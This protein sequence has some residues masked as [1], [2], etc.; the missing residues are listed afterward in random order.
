MDLAE[1]LDLI[2]QA[3]GKQDGFCFFPWID[4]TATDREQRIKSYHEGPA[5]HWPADRAQVLLHMHEH[6]ND[7]LYWC[8]S[9]FETDRRQLEVAMDEHALWADLDDVD[10]REIDEEYKPT[11]A[12]ETS[13]GRYQGLWLIQRGFDIQGASWPGGENQKLTYY[14]GADVG[15]WDITQL[16]RIPGW[17]NHKPEHRGGTR[18][19]PN[20]KLTKPPTGKLLWYDKSRRYLPDHFEDLPEVANAL[21]AIKDVLD[22][23]IDRV[24][25][26]A[27]WGRVRLKVSRRVRE[28]VG[29]KEVT[30]DRS[31]V[32]WEIERELADAGCSVVEIVAIVRET[33]WNKYEG[34]AD[35]LRR[36]TNE[37]A[38]AVAARPDK[39]AV[40]ADELEPSDDEER[41]N[42]QRLGSLL[43]TV[44][45]PA[46]LVEGIWTK[47]SCGFIAGQPKTFKS[48]CALDIALSVATG[49]P[50]LGHFPVRV[51]GPVLY[52]QEED[53]LPLL[54]QRADKVWPGKMADRM[55][56]MGDG[57]IQWVPG[58]ELGDLEDAP[59]DAYIG[60]GFTLSD[61]GW[62]SWLDE[63]L[64]A[65]EYVMLVMD[66][67]MMLAGDVEENRAQ[68]MTTKIFRPLKQLAQK[69]ECSVALVHHLR[70]G[71]NE[72]RG[73]QLMLGSV[74]N[75]AWAEDSL[76][77]R[78]SRGK[79]MVERESKHT[80]SGTFEIGNVRNKVW[81]PVVMNEA[82]DLDD[83]DESQ[84]RGEVRQVASNGSTRHKHTPKAISA[85]QELGPGRHATKKIAEQCG[86]T[87]GAVW[88]QLV[89]AEE[90]GWVERPSTQTWSLK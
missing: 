80:T 66:P 5:F 22:E 27:V 50:F 33:A 62:Q 34:R 14:L 51:P 10:P 86:L 89:R 40:T 70:K 44:K 49:Q 1:A 65:G 42:P 81:Q 59:I 64:D 30:G 83:H 52:I 55:V 2:S 3:W 75:H 4:G 56:P 29:A 69:H 54:K 19:G 24:D 87:T 78:L 11:I 47:G 25:R 60:E 28:F 90:K 45:P 84:G 43:R 39:S 74:A 77:F 72:G 71:Q 46:W 63:Q 8:P 6:Q 68:D 41:P 35:E 9:L 12:W 21:G 88:R 37:A 13:P 15:G 57:Q 73:G 7:D 23:E 79:I 17:K 76:Y 48:W 16:M 82:G 26:H 67:L 36:L 38:K 53:G 85:L 32:L 18:N 31:E 20:K 58:E 61:P